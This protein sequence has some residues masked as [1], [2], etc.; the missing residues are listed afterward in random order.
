[1]KEKQQRWVAILSLSVIVSASVAA[2][3]ELYLSLADGS[4]VCLGHESKNPNHE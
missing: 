4:V 3:R 1:M 2:G